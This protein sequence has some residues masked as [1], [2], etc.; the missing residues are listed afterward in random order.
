MPIFL[1]NPRM[2]KK[3]LITGVGGGGTGCDFQHVI[4]DAEG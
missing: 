2:S 4:L 1:W 3:V